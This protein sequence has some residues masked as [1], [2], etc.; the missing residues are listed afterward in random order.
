[1]LQEGCRAAALAALRACHRAR[2]LHRVLLH[3]RCRLLR[4]PLRCLMR[5][6]YLC[7]H[8]PPAPSAPRTCWSS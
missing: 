8:R 4:P 6:S 5:L 2:S 1:M 3:F 7:L